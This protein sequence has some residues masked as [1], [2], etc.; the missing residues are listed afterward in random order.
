MPSSQQTFIRKSSLKIQ[1]PF[2]FLCPFSSHLIR[3]QRVMFMHPG[4][5]TPVCT[6][7]LGQAALHEEEFTKRGTKLCGFSCNDSNSHKNWIKDIEV[8][9]GGE[10]KF[11]LFCD[12][13]R[14]AAVELGILDKTNK[15]AKGLPLTVRSVYI[16]KP[17][18]TIALMMTYP[19]S[20]G[21][22]FNEII[23]VLDSLQ[24][25]AKKSV[26]TPVDWKQGDDVI[27]NFP[28]SNAEADEKFGKGGYRIVQVPSEAGK[29][30]AK[31]Y[32]R[33]A[34]TAA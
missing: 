25:T 23:R 6:T 19:A 13:T 10:V 20:T 3:M 15:D 14:D 31:N 30:L 22:N 34:N 12:P 24:L 11:P 1:A 27:V 32:M 8:V 2:L 9:T 26:A 21:R 7:E 16:L 17:D 18:K 28:L 5:F 4:D 33:Y 29:V